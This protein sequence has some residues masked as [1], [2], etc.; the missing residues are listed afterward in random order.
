MHSPAEAAVGA[1]DDV[2]L[3]DDFSERDDAIGYDFRMVNE[4]GRVDDNAFQGPPARR[5]LALLLTEQAPFLLDT[6]S[7]PGRQRFFGIA[8]IV[9]HLQVHP[10]FR[11]CFEKRS[12]PDRRVA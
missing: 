3:T 4:V 6:L 11:R 1:G 8:Q 10:E 7:H 2:F 12:Q 5:F 9:G